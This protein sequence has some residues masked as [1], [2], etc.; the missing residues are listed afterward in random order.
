MEPFDSENIPAQKT[1]QNAEKFFKFYPINKLKCPIKI[2]IFNGMVQI[3]NKIKEIKL[4]SQKNS[5]HQAAAKCAWFSGNQRWVEAKIDEENFRSKKFFDAFLRFFQI[6]Q[7][8]GVVVVV[9]VEQDL[10]TANDKDTIS[11][12]LLKAILD[13][14]LIVP[15]TA[16]VMK[17]VAEMSITSEVDEK[18]AAI[19]PIILTYLTEYPLGKKIETM[20]KFFIA[21]LNYEEI[22]GRESAIAMMSLIF[23][24]FP[25]VS[26]ELQ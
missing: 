20:L 13:R 19:R 8:F 15:E 14:K 18:R 5:F 10:L 21:Q 9:I 1:W 25:Q 16:E 2:Y 11:F 12:V 17:K 26:H 7:I 23:K 6:F 22:S 4:L 3:F 24:H